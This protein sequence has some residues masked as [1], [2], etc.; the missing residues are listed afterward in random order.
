MRT[1]PTL[2]DVMYART[3][4]DA[5]TAIGA[6]V[7]ELAARYPKAPA[8]LVPDQE[9]LLTFFSY[10]GEH[11]THLRTTNLLESPFATVRPRSG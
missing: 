11:W 7:A 4:M 2:H 1:K 3:K 6:F 8:C 9:A 10:A 5:E